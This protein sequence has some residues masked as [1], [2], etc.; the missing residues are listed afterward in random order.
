MVY[1]FARSSFETTWSRKIQFV[2][3]LLLAPKKN[4]GTA[5][6]TSSGDVTAAHP[7][8]PHKVC[9]PPRYPDDLSR[10]SSSFHH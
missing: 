10:V 7:A 3:L 2:V 6:I 5:L 9:M 8:H 1:S 4:L